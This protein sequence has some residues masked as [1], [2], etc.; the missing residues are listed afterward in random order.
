MVGGLQCHHQPDIDIL[1]GKR[2]FS[3]RQKGGIRSTENKND[4]N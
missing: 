3:D 1:P 4:S 2:Y